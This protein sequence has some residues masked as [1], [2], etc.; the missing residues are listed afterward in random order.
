MSLY[1]LRGSRQKHPYLSGNFA[2]LHETC[3]ETPCSYV[4]SIPE[5]LF[6][7][8]YIRNGGNPVSNNDLGRDA[9]W[10]DGDGMLA[11][12]IFKKNEKE[13]Y[14]T[15]HFV[16]QYILTDVYLSTVAH[17]SLKTPILPSITTLV[18]PISTLVYIIFRI[19]RALFLV[20]I[21]HLLGSQ[22][23]IK[24]ISVANT[25]IIYHDGRALAT[26]ESGPPIRIQLPGLET[27]GWYDGRLAQGEPK[28]ANDAGTG[29]NPAPFGGSGVLSFLREFTTGHPKV[30]PDTG[31]MI[32]FHCTFIPPY[33]HYSIIPSTRKP[34]HDMSPPRRLLNSPIPG[35]SGAKMMH[36]FG[37]SKTHTIIMDL[38][39]SLNPF[40]LLKNQ[41]VVSYDPSKPARFGIFPRQDTSQARWFETT[42]CCIFHT[43]NAWDTLDAQGDVTAVNLLACRLTS[44]SLVF[45]AGNIAAPQAMDSTYKDERKPISFFATYDYDEVLTDLPVSNRTD[46][47]LESERKPLLPK[48][49]SNC[50]ATLN[51]DDEEQCRL[52]YY[53]FSLTTPTPTITRQYALSAIPFEFPTLNPARE[54]GDARFIYGCSTSTSSFGAALGRATKIDVLVKM[55]VHALIR[56]GGKRSPRSVTGCV[57]NRTITEIAE[58]SDLDDA[59]KCFKMPEGWYAQEARFV[60]RNLGSL[61]S[62]ED[63]GFLLFY[64][65]DE[66]QLD[67]EGECAGTAASELWIMD[68]SD[69][70]SVLAKVRL[71]Q[72]VPYGLHGSWFSEEMIRDQREVEE[73][74]KVPDSSDGEGFWRTVNRMMVKVAG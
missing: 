74:R 58:S 8:E 29:D 64:A 21:S 50:R 19:F 12:V 24:R 56:E 54:M 15:P 49:S 2:P 33:V 59:I 28:I 5:A 3:S 44:A 69:F 7:G 39:L 70:Q 68:A 9:H 17:P 35:M 20:F 61:D 65:F 38:P 67:E 52:Y 66:G 45:S 16:N 53:T 36:D 41:P 13:G 62:D 14:I 4:G 40:N 37:V 27:V 55:D 60:P 72:R 57:D 34:S 18:N 51:P 46:L 42:A 43:A 48:T 63:D 73:V 30:D 31:E 26:C 22:V 10:F 47:D 25:S 6:G 11:G 32:L 1:E 23:A 71:P